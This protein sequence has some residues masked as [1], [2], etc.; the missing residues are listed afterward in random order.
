MEQWFFRLRPVDCPSQMYVIIKRSRAWNF[1]TTI[2][3]R[4]LCV[5]VVCLIKPEPEF[6]FKIIVV[7]NMCS[8][9]KNPQRSMGWTESQKLGK[10]EQIAHHNE[11]I[12]YY[13][14]CV[15]GNIFS[16]ARFWFEWSHHLKKNRIQLGNRIV[17]IIFVHQ[18]PNC[19]SK[20]HRRAMEQKLSH[21]NW[22]IYDRAWAPKI[23]S[24]EKTVVF[25]RCFG[26]LW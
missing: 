3:Q 23:V 6:H 11:N 5:R 2:Y 26:C 21:H 12:S 9:F 1:L 4:E 24:W 14:P 19:L 15:N 20:Y 22:M 7:I 17:V 8:P 16:V 10:V 13:T 25:F 18:L